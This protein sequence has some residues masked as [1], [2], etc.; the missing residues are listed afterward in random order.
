MAALVVTTMVADGIFSELQREIDDYLATH[1][2]ALAEFMSECTSID[3]LPQ[4]LPQVSSTLDRLKWMATTISK[5]R[6]CETVQFLLGW[7]AAL[8]GGRI[9]AGRS[10]KSASWLV[11]QLI[12]KILAQLLPHTDA[13]VH[14]ASL[15]ESVTK[16]AAEKIVEQML[17]RC[18]VV[19]QET[20]ESDAAR[21]I[22]SSGGFFAFKT[23]LLSQL[24]APTPENTLQENVVAAWRGVLALISLYSLNPLR[25]RFQRQLLQDLLQ[26]KNVSSTTKDYLYLKNL[27]PLRLGVCTTTFLLPSSFSHKVKDAAIFLRI[28][29]PL[30][31]KPYRP[32]TRS[33]AVTTI[34]AM[35]NNE[36]EALDIQSLE[37][38]HTG[39]HA[40]SEWNSCISELHGVALKLTSK[41]EFAIAAWELRVALLCLCPNEIFGRYWKE[42]V[43]ALLRVQYQHNKDGTEQAVTILACVERCF[44][45]MLKRHALTERRLPSELDCMEIINTTQAWCFFAYPKYRSLAKLQRHILPMLVRI[46]IGIASYNAMYAI[47][48]HLRRL[49]LEADHLFD[50]KKLVGLES[51][52]AI[53][54]I[55]FGHE[56][57]N[58]DVPLDRRALQANRST[59]GELVGQALI[60]ANTH[61]G[62]DLL[63]ENT[64]AFVSP[65]VGASTS[66]IARL[67]KDEYRR[68]LAIQS[69]ATALTALQFL[70]GAL[71]LSDDQKMLILA[72]S[73]IHNEPLIRQS[74][75]ATLHHLIVHEEGQ[76]GAVFRCLTDYLFRLSNHLTKPRDFDAFLV[77]I[78]LIASLLKVSSIEQQHGDGRV[79]AWESRKAWQESLLQIEA[80]AVYLL[81]FE[82]SR[83]LGAAL[84]ALELVAQ[85]RPISVAVD[86]ATVTATV[87]RPRVIQVM[88]DAEW[89]LSELLF[90]F[91]SRSPTIDLGCLQRLITDL[92]TGQPRASFRWSSCLA[93]LLTRLALWNPEVAA[94]MW[95]DVTDKVA[96]LEP[97]MPPS[98]MLMESEY[99]P[100]AGG[101]FE[102]ARWR[103]LA[104]LATATACPNLL[105]QSTDEAC[106]DEDA[107]KGASV[108]SVISSSAVQ[109]L[110]K[111]LARYIKSPSMDQKKAAV[112][113]LGSTH[114][115]SLPILLEVLQ[116][117]ESEAFAVASVEHQG[118][119]HASLSE[120]TPPI[121]PAPTF[122]A[123]N[124]PVVGVRKLTKEQRLKHHKALTQ[125]L[126]Q[127]AV[128]RCYRLL[129][130]GTTQRPQCSDET[131][132]EA[133]H[134]LQLVATGVLDKLAA[135]LTRLQHNPGRSGGGPHSTAAP[136]TTRDIPHHLLFM[137][138]QDFCSSL[139][140]LAMLMA[141][142]RALGNYGS[143]RRRHKDTK[144]G[145]TRRS[146][147]SLTDSYRSDAGAPVLAVK[148]REAWYHL[149]LSWCHAF[150]SLAN[151]RLSG[152]LSGEFFAFDSPAREHWIQRCDVFGD[153]VDEAL[154]IPWHWVDEGDATRA[155]GI[156]EAAMASF[157]RFF[158][159][160]SAFASLPVVVH[161]P[162]F[163]PT[164]ITQDSAALRWIDE[165]FAVAV[166]VHETN[167]APHFA[168][169]QRCCHHVLDAFLLSAFRVFIEVC[170]DKSFFSVGSGDK[171][172]IAKHYFQAIVQ[173]ASDLRNEFAKPRPTTASDTTSPI[174]VPLVMANGKPF[175]PSFATVTNLQVRLGHVILLHLGIDSDTEQR[176]YAV[177][178]IN[179]LYADR[180]DGSETHD[181]FRV[182]SMTSSVKRA[183]P[184]FLT[185]VTNRMQVAGASYLVGKLPTLAFSMSMSILKFLSCCEP[186]QQRKMLTVVLPWLAEVSLVTTTGSHDAEQL[187]SLLFRITTNLSAT[188]SDQLEQAWLTLAFASAA[189]STQ[190]S[191]STNLGIALQFLFLQRAT[192][193]RLS[194]AKAV[195]W[196][197]CRWQSA[198]HEVLRELL[199]RVE[200][201]R[202]Q[203]TEATTSAQPTIQP[204]DD[205]F[206][207][208]I[209]MS[210]SCCHLATIPSYLYQHPA[211]REAMMVQAVHYAFLTLFALALD[212]KAFAVHRAITSP[213]GG[214]V[215]EDQQHSMY[216]DANN[217]CI[218][219]LRNIL[220]QLSAPTELLEAVI[221]DLAEWSSAWTNISTDQR[222]SRSSPSSFDGRKSS[223]EFEQ[224]MAAFASCLPLSIRN[225]WALECMKEITLAL[226]PGSTLLSPTSSRCNNVQVLYCVRFGLLGY[227]VLE[228][229]FHGDVFLS[230]LDLLHHSLEEHP[231]DPPN[232]NAVICDTLSVLKSMV[233]A[234][235]PQ[236]LA[237]YPQVLWVCVAL[238][239][240]HTP[241]YLPFHGQ[242]IELLVEVLRVPHFATNALLHD[243][244]LSKRPPR[245]SKEQ[246]SV[247]H[248]L[249]WNLDRGKLTS[250]R[251][252]LNVITRLLVLPSPVYHADPVEHLIISTVALIPFLVATKITDAKNDKA[253]QFIASRKINSVEDDE[254]EEEEESEDG[255]V[256][257]VLWSTDAVC[258]TTDLQYAWSAAG[259]T[260]L[261]SVFASMTATDDTEE[262]Q[263]ETIDDRQ[264]A[265]LCTHRFT[266]AFVAHLRAS[267][268]SD[269]VSAWITKCFEILIKVLVSEDISKQEMR[270]KHPCD[271]ATA[272]SS[273]VVTATL[274]LVEA[275]MLELSQ[276]KYAWRPTT[277]LLG[278]L[279]RIVREPDQTQTWR[280]AVRIMN[281]LGPSGRSISS[282]SQLLTPVIK[283]K[284]P[285]LTVAISSPS[286][287]TTTNDSP[288][289]STGRN[290]SGSGTPGKKERT[291]SGARM[292]MGLLGHRSSP[293]ASPSHNQT[294]GHQSPAHSHF[295]QSS[296]PETQDSKRKQHALSLDPI[297][298]RSASPSAVRR[299]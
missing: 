2:I 124:G 105:Y 66:A 184:V 144:Q 121:T 253:E 53:L 107:S 81:V 99:A 204:V 42:D 224:A 54:R 265:R 67:M 217:D 174:K 25:L 242:V 88:R 218:V 268:S 205:V 94:F 159:C 129:L 247:L 172:N 32:A 145:S 214:A 156:E 295:L 76:A 236:R 284:K 137:L 15:M 231:R 181:V 279:A 91:D 276:H 243:I 289:H 294:S 41:R 164:P 245:W 290:P 234:M 297:E 140:S 227:R 239:N 127:W 113:A 286:T 190:T 261:C 7:L 50:E 230:L 3:D 244:L 259:D 235:P 212:P 95:N 141:E 33:T 71:A 182:N 96:K 171:H 9:D 271:Q 90:S 249:V 142:N 187:L 28:L 84:E 64:T 62:A 237:L 12:T 59:L 120:I 150:S 207:F 4:H 240:Q 189:E 193:V 31:Q 1:A 35:L 273:G 29:Q 139:R 100:Q 47:Q 128:G 211:M 134:R 270:R 98:N 151:T 122:H 93:V 16:D 195:V 86:E 255:F 158:L 201:R 162:L 291:S 228:P 43:H 180:Q 58:D 10:I 278:S 168:T 176:Q 126:L 296:E 185:Q 155:L 52:L 223:R 166:N 272:S 17:D 24:R 132:R 27:T 206:V 203:S 70:Y 5:S 48:S 38:V 282:S 292:L 277:T 148:Q 149:L 104:V 20:F 175:R 75:T 241:D 46:S 101:G 61:F 125:L 68:S 60:E 40:V 108:Q 77:L 143:M 160:Q 14:R 285:Q 49:L 154:V 78:Q 197:L 198:A 281:C 256:D 153:R 110:F 288:P 216:V 196:W 83:L 79:C 116:R 161:G 146:C 147:S 44:V 74:A 23:P 179:E 22:E 293:S 274:W 30:T 11:A 298:E 199:M 167:A 114:V 135:S 194:T 72:R 73:C 221:A 254:S 63:I 226:V 106:E 6:L 152:N 225:A 45:H 232:A 264:P 21:A 170:V 18:V 178:L 209:L 85:A 200:R 283:V 258:I 136:L 213:S 299:N 138:Q 87:E 157:E 220:S 257:G 130:R 111:R 56:R 219:F 118:S 169:L 215:G 262:A 55:A 252:I 191:P 210:D 202:E 192:P 19:F 13:A 250:H 103:N 267:V 39:V 92:A 97:V 233:A 69:Y 163:L 251:L 34:A 246:A 109:S 131:T 222:F 82:D 102:L 37:Q 266:E 173:V 188:C 117:Y 26:S 280:A 183:S 115:S 275:F 238:L 248:T 269:L 186:T 112:L 89:E 263:P 177:D 287:G 51:L 133:L 65:A 36:L 208:V 165:C 80:I 57:R 229:E 260:S 123:M 119:R 8:E